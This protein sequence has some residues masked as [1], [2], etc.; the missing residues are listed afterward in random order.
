MT[1]KILIVAGDGIGP[2]VMGQV[3]RVIDW[4]K[5]ARGFD[6]AVDRK[7]VV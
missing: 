7:S 6:V 1:K 2:E 3:E 5:G 4:F